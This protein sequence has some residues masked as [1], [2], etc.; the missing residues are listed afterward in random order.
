LSWDVEKLGLSYEACRDVLMDGDPRIAVI[1]NLEGIEI[2][3]INLAPREERIIGLRLSEVL[4]QAA[5][6]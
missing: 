1:P 4:R 3:S 5:R 6:R 2:I